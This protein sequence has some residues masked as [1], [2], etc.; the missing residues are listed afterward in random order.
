[1]SEKIEP[2]SPDAQP[3]GRMV[4]N[5]REIDVY[6]DCLFPSGERKLAECTQHLQDG[7][8]AEVHGDFIYGGIRFPEE[9]EE[10]MVRYR[11]ECAGRKLFKG[12]GLCIVQY[13]R[14]GTK[15]D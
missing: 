3:T 4:L 14:D 5:D 1:M 6:E 9:D 13:D 12:C 8:A 15:I 7:A 11:Y 10:P 2:L